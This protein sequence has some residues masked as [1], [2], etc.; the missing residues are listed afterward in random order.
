[1]YT[2]NFFLQFQ[3]LHYFDN[4]RRN[5]FALLHNAVT[6]DTGLSVEEKRALRFLLGAT[7]ALRPDLGFSLMAGAQ[8]MRSEITGISRE[9]L[10]GGAED[11]VF[12]R[13]RTMWSPFVGLELAYA[14]AL[15]GDV[16]AQIFL[17]AGAAWMGD[18]KVS[19]T[20]SNFGFDYDFKVEGG[21]RPELLFGI[22]LA[23]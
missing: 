12:R 9:T 3:Y 18:T 13:N 6:N 7:F 10:G 8:M 14:L 20:S 4:E 22:R 19:G 23:W 1:L 15:A 17:A 2:P 11:Q 21:I 5:L 16:N